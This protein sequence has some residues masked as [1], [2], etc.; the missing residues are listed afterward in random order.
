MSTRNHL[1]YEKQIEKYLHS[2]GIHVDIGSDFPVK[3]ELYDLIVPLNF[4]KKLNQVVNHKNVVVFHTSDLPLGKGWS[5]IAN[6]FLNKEKFY[7][8]TCFVA[9]SSIDAGDILMKMRFKIRANDTATS[10]R[11]IDDN[12]MIIGILLILSHFSGK[13]YSG[14]SQENQIGTYFSKRNKEENEIFLD[15]S[16]GEI[17]PILRSAEKEHNCFVTKDG[18]TFELVL[19]PMIE[20]EF[21]S[22]ITVEFLFKNEKWNLVTYLDAKNL[23]VLLPEQL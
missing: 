8:L 14:I 15:Q 12:L 16:I 4:P 17:L 9:N 20:P 13:E 1:K 5:P 11:K 6:I 3:P 7:C 18:Y 19:K 23:K 10:I 21:P 22:D 2:Q